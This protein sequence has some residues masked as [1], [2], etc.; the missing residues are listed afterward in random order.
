MRRPPAFGRSQP[1]QSCLA[2]PANPCGEPT[3]P[4][5][6]QRVGPMFSCVVVVPLPQRERHR[7]TH[8]SSVC[9]TCTFLVPLLQAGLPFTLFWRIPFRVNTLLRLKPFFPPDYCPQDRSDFSRHV[10]MGRIK[11]TPDLWRSWPSLRTGPP[12]LPSVQWPM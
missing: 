9:L 12:I 1:A 2:L 5:G 3:S 7:P 11:A 4:S 8:L 10:P 6:S